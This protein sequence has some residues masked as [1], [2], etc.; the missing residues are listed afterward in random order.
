[1]SLTSKNIS[2]YI[3]WGG[4]SVL[5]GLLIALGTQ[6][7][8]DDPI[9]WRR[10][11]EGTIQ[12]LITVVTAMVAASRLPRPGSE[13]LSKQVDNL[14]DHGVP[15]SDMVVL[16]KEEVETIKSEAAHINR[17]RPLREAREGF[18]PLTAAEMAQTPA[19]EARDG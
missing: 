12:A 19:D 6:L 16:S 15:K 4:L 11:A 5:L 13:A 2:N 8:G 3:I 9:N 17:V 10:V 1:M 14:Q 18:K 7:A